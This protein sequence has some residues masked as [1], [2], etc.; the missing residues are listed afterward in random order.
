MQVHALHFQLSLGPSDMAAGIHFL[1]FR[2]C[3]ADTLCSRQG[4]AGGVQV[5]QR[6][7]C[8]QGPKAIQA[9]C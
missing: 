3:V 5:G 8:Q 6:E 9:D 4:A 1:A 2:P 7:P